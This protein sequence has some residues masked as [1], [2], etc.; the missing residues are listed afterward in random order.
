M[1]PPMNHI[2]HAGIQKELDLLDE[3]IDTLQREKEAAG[4]NDQ[5]R[6]VEEAREVQQMAR[7]DYSRGDFQKA[8]LEVFRAK[9]CLF[10]GGQELAGHKALMEE[11]RALVDGP[12]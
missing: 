6:D 9:Y 7:E 5:P 4:D 12:Q 8:F 1:N 11:I 2:L 3:L 10:F